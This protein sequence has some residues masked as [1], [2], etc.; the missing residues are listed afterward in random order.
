MGG[1]LVCSS[2]LGEGTE[3]VFTFE[4]PVAQAPEDQFTEKGADLS[5]R[6]IL[7]VED[8]ELNR[9][10][11]TEILSEGG[12][13]VTEVC[14]GA[15]AVELLQQRGIASFDAV[16]MDIQMPVMDG[17]TATRLIRSMTEPAAATVPIIAMTADA[18]AEDKRRAL[19]AGF[20]AH[21]AKPVNMA[22]LIDTL[23]IYMNA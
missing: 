3:F 19:E 12:I 10:I 11:A 15:E 5:G 17:Y 16:L 2:T 21:L 20:T 13:L 1:T 7:L 9:E 6:K 8:N 4:L 22:T 18:F 23:S 14:N